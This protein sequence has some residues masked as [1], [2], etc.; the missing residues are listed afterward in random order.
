MN[1][2]V[3][4]PE[5]EVPVVSRTEIQAMESQRLERE[6]NLDERL[7]QVRERESAL[8]G[9]QKTSRVWLTVTVSLFGIMVAAGVTITVA[10]LQ[11]LPAVIGGGQ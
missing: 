11:S 3:I 9:A 2:L 8:E 4:R 5:P 10:I 7:A 6:R 1:D